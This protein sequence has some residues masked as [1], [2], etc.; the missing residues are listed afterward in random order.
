MALNP[1][2]R[3]ISDHGITL[4]LP[5]YRQQRIGTALLAHLVA[6]LPGVD[7]AW[8]IIAVNTIAVLAAG[9]VATILT[10]RSG[11]S[12][13]WAA[14]LAVPANLPISLGRDLTEPLAWTLVLLGIWAARSNRWFPAAL[15]FTGAVLSRETSILVVGG[16]GLYALVLLVRG[17]RD[18]LPRLW[19]LLPVAAVVG[20]Q[21]YLHHVWGVWP[22][23]T[24]SSN[25]TGTPFLGPFTSLFSAPPA[26]GLGQRI[27]SAGDVVEHLVFLLLLVAVIVQ[28]VR[29]RIAAPIGER[30]AW[31]AATLLALSLRRWFDDV[32]FL[33]AVYDAWSLSVLLLI[34]VPQVRTR[35][36]WLTDGPLLA[37]GAVSAAVTVLYAVRI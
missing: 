18:A 14:V 5:A 21:V 32:S 36:R 3:K 6:E 28:L 22:F 2:T 9:A 10:A 4:D 23:R 1:F 17:C 26:H 13:W 20:W 35:A 16:L 7:V 34:S 15:A 11:R 31:V 19:L 8:A 24:G 27:L 12:L 30:I 37:A 25:N 33:R 29:A